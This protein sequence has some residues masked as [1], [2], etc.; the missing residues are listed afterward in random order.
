MILAI[1]SAALPAQAQTTWYVDATNCPGPGSGSQ[2]DPFCHIQ[3]AIDAS[4]NGD[5]VVVAPG[6]YNEL[7]NFNGKQ[8]SKS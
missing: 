2:V 5:E 3:P 6:T 1:A 4:T 8:S 7:I